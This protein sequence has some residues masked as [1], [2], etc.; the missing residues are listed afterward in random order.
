MSWIVG[1]GRWALGGVEKDCQ[2]SSTISATLGLYEVFFT[3][4]GALY[5]PTPYNP[6]S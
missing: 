3:P 2:L 4:V 5:R 1:P 6:G